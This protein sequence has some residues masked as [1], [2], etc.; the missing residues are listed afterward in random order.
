MV[1]RGPVFNEIKVL[2]AIPA[3]GTPIAM[4]ERDPTIR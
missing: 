1:R 4:V 3:A 2:Q